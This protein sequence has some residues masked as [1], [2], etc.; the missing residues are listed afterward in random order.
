MNKLKYL[1]IF[2]ILA[3]SLGLRG[4]PAFLINGQPELGARPFEHFQEGL[5][6]LL[7]DRTAVPR[8]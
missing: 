8:P 5:N 6:V 7:K 4:T 2:I 1:T 3:V